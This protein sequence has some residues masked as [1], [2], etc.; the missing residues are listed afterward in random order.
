MDVV[1]EILDTPHDLGVEIVVWKPNRGKRVR[2]GILKGAHALLDVMREV[3]DT[4]HDL[5]V[6]IFAMFQNIAPK[7]SKE[8]QRKKFTTVF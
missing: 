5:R 6:E 3:L 8:K 1:C 7:H 4:L 2:N